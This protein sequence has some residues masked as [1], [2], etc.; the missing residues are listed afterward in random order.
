MADRDLGH[1]G[2]PAIF[3]NAFFGCRVNNDILQNIESVCKGDSNLRN[4]MSFQ[5]AQKGRIICPLISAY[6]FEEFDTFCDDLMHTLVP[7]P[8]K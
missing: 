6:I 5:M 4:K 8:P 7:N 3:R 1:E 2:G